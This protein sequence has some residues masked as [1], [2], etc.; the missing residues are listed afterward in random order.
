MEYNEENLGTILSNITE[1]ND[2]KLSDIPDINLYMDQV[3]TLFDM[4]LKSLK[5]D[6]ND[7][8]MTKLWLIIM[9][10]ENFS[11]CKGQKIQ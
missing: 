8:I 1:F 10:K 4:K 11:S 3:T 6:E 2:I 5:R 9:L 7:K